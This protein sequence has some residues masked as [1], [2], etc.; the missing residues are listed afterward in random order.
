[1]TAALP[2]AVTSPEQGLTGAQEYLAPILEMRSGVI[3]PAANPSRAVFLSY[4]SQD[5]QAAQR[6]CD[7]LRSAAIDVWF[8][9]SELRGGEAWDQKIRQRIRDCGLFIAL[10]SANTDARPEGYFRLEWKLAVDRSHLM[11][12]D[13]P[14]LVPVVI[15]GTAEAT[16]RVPDRFR[17]AH[18]IRL[19]AGS[20]PAQLPI[21]IA[22]LLKGDPDIPRQT[23]ATP[24]AAP[25]RS[26]R[27]TAMMLVLGA[28]ALVACGYLLLERIA[29][30]QRPAQPAPSTTTGT[31][32]GVAA[33]A[34]VSEKSIAVLPFIDMSER[35]DQE[36]F[37]DGL[38]EELIDRLAH[39]ANLKVIARTSSFQFKGKNDDIRLIGQRLGAANLLEGSVR[40]SGR[41]VRV[42]AQ[43]ISAS[44]GSHR[45]SQTYDRDMQDIFKVQDAI[46]TAVVASLEETISGPARSQGDRPASPDAYKAV[47][48]GRY[49]RQKGT[50]DDAER[51]VAEFK[52]ALNIDPNNA[53]AAAELARAYNYMGLGGWTPPRQA[54]S[55]AREAAHRAL[56]LDPSLALTHRVLASIAW[57]YDFDYKTGRAEDRRATELDPDAPDVNIGHGLDAIAAGHPDLALGYFRKEVDRDP[58]NPQAWNNLLLAQWDFGQIAEAMAT[59]KTILELS[60][61]YAGAHCVLGQLLLDQRKPAEALAEM[62]AET[63]E[64]SRAAC[65]PDAL[66]ELGRHAEADTMLADA[67]MKYADVAA[68]GF[69][70]SY[71]RRSDRDAAFAWLDRAVQNREPYVTM[72][73]SDWTLR[74]LHDDPRWAALLKKLNLPE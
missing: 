56:A 41:R 49:F 39:V 26:L 20:S 53:T 60:P 45:W 24:P 64:A 8:D 55:E 70:T 66:W 10:I 15:D 58:L 42:T 71:A 21:R 33:P 11:A 47:L 32:P 62:H 1:M 16:A 63:D 31:A 38:A 30:S 44:D 4:A 28:V 40:T 5:A 68:T 48:R 69:A 9:Q 35:K 46:A 51:A 25:A 50:K 22:Q 43:L 65:V 18:W 19:A 6:I 73:K 61:Q 7:A 2:H 12:D 57:N 29:S 23:A 54:A 14:F 74:S 72:I 67:E 3:L 37:S 59:A 13:E 17:Q 36:Y 52:H 34:A 27:P